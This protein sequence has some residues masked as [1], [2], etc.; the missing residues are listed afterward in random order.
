MSVQGILKRLK[1][2]IKKWNINQNGNIE[3]KIK[4]AEKELEEL[5]EI[6]DDTGQALNMAV[7]LHELYNIREQ[8]LKQKARVQWDLE[9]D[10]NTRFYHQAIQKRRKKNCIRKVWW[11][12]KWL[13]SPTRIKDAFLTYF[14]DFFS[15]K[16][17]N[18]AF[19]VGELLSVKLSMEEAEWIQTDLTKDEL[20]TALTQLGHNKAHG[21][22]GMTTEFLIKWWDNLSDSF[23]K[24]VLDFMNG[25][26]V[27]YGMSAAAISLIPKK[28][29]PE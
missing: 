13:Y 14:K 16:T 21:L 26:C 6:G 17:R 22:D 2:C 9:G 3:S 4:R 12:G 24:T 28:L 15:N 29:C 19:G 18:I 5:E 20:H 7:K 11:K 1:D 10:K 23:M 25:R 8:M 27:P